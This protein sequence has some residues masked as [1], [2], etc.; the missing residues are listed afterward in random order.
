[1]ARLA[2]LVVPHQPHHVIQHGID[3]QP[4]FRDHDDYLRFLGWLREAAKTCKVAIHAYVLMPT[5]LHLL[6]TPSDAT[7]LSR[8]MQWIGRNYVPYF[9]QKYQRTG[10][11]WG[12]RY[13]ATVIDAEEYLMKCSRYIESHPVRAGLVN[14]PADYRWSSYAHHIGASTDPL[15]SDHALYWALGN[16]PFEREATYRQLVEQGSSKTEIEVLT[17]ATKK[18]WALGSEQFKLQLEKQ[19]KRRVSPA[20][21]GR[22]AKIEK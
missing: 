11:L 22:P 15:I 3:N 13:K 8:M 20:K 10:T 21:R 2:R 7:G 1:M 12:S 6:L 17:A 18:G 16:T 4:I 5:H 14:Y 9:N 19:I